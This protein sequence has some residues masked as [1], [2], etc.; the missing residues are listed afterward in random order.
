MYDLVVAILEYLVA[1][2]VFD[3]EV[4]VETEPFGVFP[5]VFEL[6]DMD[7]TPLSLSLRF[8]SS[9]SNYSW[10]FSSNSLIASFQRLL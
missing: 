7:S 8:W 9:G 3:V 10:I 2:D 6:N 4:S 5:L 1:V